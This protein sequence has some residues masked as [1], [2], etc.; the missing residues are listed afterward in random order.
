M[1][2]LVIDDDYDA[3][4]VMQNVLAP[5]GICDAATGGG[6]ALTLFAKAC[7][8]GKPYDL[9]LLDIMMPDMDGNEVRRAIRAEEFRR[10]V[11]EKKQ[12]RII[13]LTAL[14]DKQNAAAAFR[15]QC[16]AFFVKPIVIQDLLAKI[17]AMGLIPPG[18]A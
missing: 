3:R 7:D 6:E 8:E 2:T 16:D 17:Q 15:D 12:A 11:E 5:Y 14:S 10:N 9:V 18:R 13:M 1:K 4:F